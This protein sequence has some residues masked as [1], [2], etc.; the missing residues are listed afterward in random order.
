MYKDVIRSS[1][2]FS[3]LSDD[4]IEYALRFF[5]ARQNEYKRGESLN[6]IGTRLMRFGLVLSGTVQVYMDDIDGNQMIMATVEHG[7]TFGESLCYLGRDADVY[8]CALSD[9]SVLWL[10]ADNVHHPTGGADVELVGRF[11]SMLAERALRIND[12]IQVLS[13][14]TLR[15]KLIT[16]FSQ[17][18]ARC[19]TSFTLT[20]DR[21]D[22]AVYLGADRSSLSRELSRMKSEGIIDYNKREFTIKKAL[23]SQDIH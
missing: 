7:D 3:G 11:I 10:A 21:K 22:M 5:D 6:I 23:C 20:F 19:G 4:S 2:L 1:A 14:L 16:F 8:I 12:R 17:Y 18:V 15:D 13:R 9:T